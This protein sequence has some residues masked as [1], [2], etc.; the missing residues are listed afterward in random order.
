LVELVPAVVEWNRGPLGAL[1]DHP[2][3]DARV[4]VEV[5]DM[6][7]WIEQS[8]DVVDAI[9]LDVD[10]GPAALTL[11]SNR[12][13]YSNDVRARVMRLLH[14]GGVLATWSVNRVRDFESRL[15]NAGFKTEVHG[16]PGAVGGPYQDHII[17]VSQNATGR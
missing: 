8:A 11:E 5:A 15:G 3:D 1:T 7:V 16:I 17:Y 14:C 9:L 13:L 10:N 2:L 6:C 4:R 12:A